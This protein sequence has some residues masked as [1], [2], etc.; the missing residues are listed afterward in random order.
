MVSV[1]KSGEKLR[2]NREKRFTGLQVALAEAEA[3][4]E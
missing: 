1:M 3:E 2:P 4:T